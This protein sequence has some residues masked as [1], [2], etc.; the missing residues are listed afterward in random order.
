MRL[1]LEAA[2]NAGD[3]QKAVTLLDALRLLDPSDPTLVDKLYAAR[4]NYG[5]QLLLAGNTNGALA[6]CQ[7]ALELRPAGVE[8]Q[9][10]VASAAPRP[11]ATRY[12]PPAPS[13]TT[14]SQ[15]FDMLVAVRGY[16]PWG[17]P[18]PTC[19]DGF[20]DQSAVRKFLVDLTITNRSTQAVEWTVNFYSGSKNLYSCVFGRQP[21]GP[22]P[23]LP[24][25]STTTV[26]FA[27]FTELNESV[28][29]LS[30]WLYYTH[31]T[32]CFAPGDGHRVPC[33]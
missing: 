10:C 33:P 5:R 27:A 31:I 3:W 18:N 15:P 16:Q 28:T 11:T 4:V 9:Q 25:S 29:D 2:W 6:Q 30:V 13:P 8:A 20:N 23:E 17:R 7:G 22:I 26:T 21:G 32:A 24:P 1:Q 19:A 14:P 12:V